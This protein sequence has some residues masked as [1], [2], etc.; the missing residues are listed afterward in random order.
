MSAAA[1]ACPLA[2]RKCDWS[3]VLAGRSTTSEQK[4]WE[5]RRLSGPGMY[6]QAQGLLI[7]LR[8]SQVVLVRGHQSLGREDR[9]Y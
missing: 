5:S 4:H 1:G 9:T 6:V 7:Q 2:T 8:Q 3:A